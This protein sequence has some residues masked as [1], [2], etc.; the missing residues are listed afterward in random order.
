MKLKRIIGSLILKIFGWTDYFPEDYK[1]QKCVLITAPHTSFLDYIFT[2]ASFWKRKVNVKFVYIHEETNWFVRTFYKSIGGINTR[3]S[4]LIINSANLI[5]NSQKIILIVPS[6]NTVKKINKWK[7][8]FYDVATLTKVP[9]ALSYL[10]YSDKIA[11]VGGLFNVSGDYKKD[12]K[13]IQK[14]YDSFTP[15]NP[16]YYNKNIC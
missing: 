10:D 11:G 3:E 7:T 9:L 12:I 2:F 8:G 1:V 16:D 15:K 4:A 5:N 13:K 14:F 6:E